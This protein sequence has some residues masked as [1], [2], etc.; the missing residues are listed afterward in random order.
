LQGTWLTNI[1]GIGKASA[2]ALSKAGW[3]VV[4]TAR[5]LEHL[6]EV[7]ILCPNET[8]ILAGDL[9][10]EPFVKGLFE[11]AHAHFGMWPLR[12]LH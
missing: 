9:L 6:K 7:A 10:D 3:N 4:L 11:V 5:R 8:L 2:V 1:L 12:H